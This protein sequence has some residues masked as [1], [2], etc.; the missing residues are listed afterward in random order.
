MNLKFKFGS[1]NL[2]SAPIAPAIPV[3]EVGEW[4]SKG[5]EGGI[6][7]YGVISALNEFK[8]VERFILLTV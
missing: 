4:V 2:M 7:R 5:S 6:F 3:S 1:Q 8:P